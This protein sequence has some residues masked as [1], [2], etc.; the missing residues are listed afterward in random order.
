M[1]SRY[2]KCSPVNKNVNEWLKY[3]G[4]KHVNDT[5]II[6][7]PAGYD[8][9]DTEFVYHTF[10][11]Y[12]AINQHNPDLNLVELLLQAGADPNF[13]V[14]KGFWDYSRSST[15]LYTIMLNNNQW[16]DNTI[17][18]IKLLIKHGVNVNAEHDDKSISL[19]HVAYAWTNPYAE[20]IMALLIKHGAD[21]NARDIKYK[22]P[23][24]N[25]LSSHKW[26]HRQ[27]LTIPQ[28]ITDLLSKNRE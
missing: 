17:D 25:V 6:T 27:N 4:F 2:S 9:G 23:H 10:P 14:S 28:N 1:F 19:H 8:Y 21:I 13:H 11:L 7:V 16:N 15:V 24:D 22:T 26:S 18:L 20:K 5:Q 12:K 3:N